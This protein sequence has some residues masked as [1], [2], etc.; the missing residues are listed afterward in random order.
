MTIKRTSSEKKVSSVCPE[1]FHTNVFVIDSRRSKVLGI[2]SIRRRRRCADC[3]Y[4][5]TTFEIHKDIVDTLEFLSYHRD[6]FEKAIPA[7]RKLFTKVL[8]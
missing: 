7:I 1:C 3:R 5:F 6:T 2:E 8:I 4:A